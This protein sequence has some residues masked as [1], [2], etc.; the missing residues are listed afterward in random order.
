MAPPYSSK[1]PTS[2]TPISGLLGD[3]IVCDGLSGIKVSI[4]GNNNASSGALA[5]PSS[6]TGTQNSAFGVEALKVNTSGNSNVAVGFQALKEN[7]AGFNNTAVGT[8]ALV[9]SS[10]TNLNTAIGH[11]SL[12]NLTTNS[13]NIAVG[14]F[15]GKFITG[16]STANSSS[17]TSIYLGAETKASASGESNQIVIGYNAVGNGSNSATIGASTIT[18]SVI[19]G[20]MTTPTTSTVMAA[21]ATDLSLVSTNFTLIPWKTTS[22]FATYQRTNIGSNWSDISSIYTAPITGIYM[23]NCAVFSD[24]IESVNVLV[25]GTN[26]N[27]PP[28]GNRTLGIAKFP[29]ASG[30]DDGFQGTIIM[31]LT[32]NDQV[33]LYAY[34]GSAG[35]LF[36]NDIH[37]WLQIRLLG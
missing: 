16:G 6:T 29:N 35:R 4:T 1:P 22:G 19:Y 5:L 25:N 9:N 17:S 10:S 15:A 27:V 30:V 2:T 8:L 21:L 32:S 36:A 3:N 24:T 33:R 7:L 37:T 31:N 34:A 11:H 13:N 26:A 14:A 20:N 28:V 12:F 23:I 18:K